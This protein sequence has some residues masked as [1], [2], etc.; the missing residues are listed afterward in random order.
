MIRI[1]TPRFLHVVAEARAIGELRHPGLIGRLREILVQN[2]IQPFLPPTVDVR[3]GTIVSL[4]G[5]REHR[6]QDDIVLFSHE[7]APLLM[8]WEQAVM[9]IEG[10]LAQIEVKSTLTRADVRDAVLAA[11][12]LRELGAGTAPI[13]MLFAFDSDLNVQ[14]EADRL[15]DVLREVGFVAV[16]GQ[17]TSPIQLITVATRGTWTLT[18]RNGVSGWWFVPPDEARH[19]FTFASVISNTIYHSRGARYGVGAYLLDVE[20]LVPPATQLPVLVPSD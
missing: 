17:A 18:S 12:E 1:L 6:I 7:A 13:G 9:P 14:S 3:T 15:M 11:V 8:D 5:E 16:A 10:V 4:D 19:L 20:W 2:V